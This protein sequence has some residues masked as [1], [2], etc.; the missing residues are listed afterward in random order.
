MMRPVS[1]VRTGGVSAATLA[2]GALLLTTPAAFALN[3]ALDV[4]QYGHTSWKIRDG[5]FKSRITVIAQTPDGYLWIGTELGLLRF[6]GVRS[7]PL[8]LPAGQSLP[9]SWVRSLFVAH[10]GALWIGTLGG[11]ARWKDGTLRRYPDVKGIV[12]AVLE[13]REGTVW[14]GTNLGIAS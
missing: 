11:L 8:Q 13:D 3:P 7:V 6:D 9:H 4:S 10:D 2:I 12:D 5:F 14:A 1:G